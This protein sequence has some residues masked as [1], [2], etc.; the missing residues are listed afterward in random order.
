MHAEQAED[1]GY[2]RQGGQQHEPHAD[3]QPRGQGSQLADGSHQQRG[4]GEHDGHGRGRNDLAGAAQGDHQALVRFL[5]LPQLLPV[6]EQ[7]EHDVVRADAEHHDDQQGRQLRADREPEPLGEEGG[8]GLGHLVHQTDDE[9]GQDGDD[10]A[11]EHQRQ[12]DQDQQDGGDRDDLLGPVELARLIDRDGG[13]PGELAP[14]SRP[15]QEGVGVRSQRRDGG[16]G[17]VVA[18]LSGHGDL[19][20]LDLLVLRQEQGRRGH[21]DARSRCDRRPGPWRAHR[22]SAGR[23]P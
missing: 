12:Q 14:Q 8:E 17:A 10:H 13:V 3:D 6:A 21:R 22:S 4:E 15:G 18:R 19:D 5:P 23:P 1:G 16:I 11:A 7:Q 9:Q 20:Q 2:Q